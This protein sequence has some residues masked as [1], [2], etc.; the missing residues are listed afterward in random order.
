[1]EM[2]EQREPYEPRGS[3]TVLGGARGEIP[4]AYSSKPVMLTGA[5]V[6]THI[7]SVVHQADVQFACFVLCQGLSKVSAFG[8]TVEMRPLQR[9]L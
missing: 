4:W 5:G 7:G 2:A 9:F 3:R 8:A 6:A 1:M